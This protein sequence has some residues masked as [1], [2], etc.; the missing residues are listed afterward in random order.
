VVV[1]LLIIIQFSLGAVRDLAPLPPLG[2]R[3]LPVIDVDTPE[4]APEVETA[5]T[6]LISSL[7]LTLDGQPSRPVRSS[8]PTAY[9]WGGDP[10]VLRC[11]VPRPAGFLAGVGTLV[12][13]EVEWFF[14]PSAAGTT[15]TAVDRG[16]YI[17]VSAPSSVDGGAVLAIL[18]PIIVAVL[19]YV[20][21][22]PG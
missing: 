2:Q 11:G 8:L 4:V 22:T 9:A 21:P 16:T 17:E 20:A 12:I 10:T 3:S 1:V 7:P 5:C 6:S 15:Y 19:P 14:E 18:A 13:N